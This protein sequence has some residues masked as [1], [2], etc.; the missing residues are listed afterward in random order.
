VLLNL[1]SSVLGEMQNNMNPQ[2]NPNLSNDAKELLINNL[3]GVCQ[4]LLVK[5]N[6]NVFTEEMV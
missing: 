5:V 1:L 6:P 3:G 2:Y 4:V